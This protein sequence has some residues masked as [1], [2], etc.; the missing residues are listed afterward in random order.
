MA[1]TPAAPQ[2]REHATATA[3][4]DTSDDRHEAQGDGAV[5]SDESGVGTA[6]TAIEATPSGS[7]DPDVDADPHYRSS[8]QTQ[9]V[10]RLHEAVKKGDVTAVQALLERGALQALL[11]RGALV[12]EDDQDGKSAIHLATHHCHAKVVELLK[13][14][15]VSIDEHDTAGKTQLVCEAESGGVKEVQFLLTNGASIDATDLELKTALFAAAENGHLEVARL[16]VENHATVDAV[17]QQSR[18]PLFDAA[19]QGHVE[20]VKFLVDRG[21][22]VDA[23]QKLGRTPLMLAVSNG[24]LDVASFLLEHSSAAAILHKDKNGWT[25]LHVAVGNGRTELVSLLVAKNASIDE[26]GPGGV[27]PLYLAAQHGHAKVV[28]LLIKA[29]AAVDA[30]QDQGRTSL[31]AAVENGSVQIAKLLIDAGASVHEHDEDGIS[32]LHAAASKGHAAIAQLLVAGGASMNVRDSQEKTALMAAAKFGHFEIVKFLVAKRANVDDTETFGRTALMLAISNRH[33]QVVDFLLDSGASLEVK[34]HAGWS[35]LHVAAGIKEK[36]VILSMLI[37][38]GARIDE[39]TLTGETPLDLAI[40][41]GCGAVISELLKSGA[42]SVYKNPDYPTLLISA[43]R[44]GHISILPYFMSRGGSL[45]SR[46]PED[47][48]TILLSTAR[49]GYRGYFK[50]LAIQSTLESAKLSDGKVSLLAGTL[51]T[52]KELCEGTEESKTM[53]TKVV[54]RLADICLQLQAREAVD[55]RDKI[56]ADIVYRVCRQLLRCRGRPAVARFIA[57]DANIRNLR[58]LH[59]EI[60][61]FMKKLNISGEAATHSNW[62]ESWATD[63]KKQTKQLCDTVKHIT[64]LEDELADGQA[65]VDA[66]IHLQFLLKNLGKVESTDKSTTEDVIRHLGGGGDSK[67]HIPV[68]FISRYNIDIEDWNAVGKSRFVKGRWVKSDVMISKCNL[69]LA[70]FEEIAATWQKLGHPNVLDLFGACHASQPRFFVCDTAKDQTLKGHL[71]NNRDL[72]TKLTKLHEAA[73]G[74]LYLQKREIVLGNLTTE[75]ILVGEDGKTKIGGFELGVASVIKS[76][77]NNNSRSGINWTSPEVQRGGHPSYASDVYALGVC[78]LD[79]LTLDDP[80]RVR[81]GS[82]LRHYLLRSATSPPPGIV[83]VAHWR[84]VKEMCAPNP[85][86]RVVIGHVVRS[87]EYFKSAAE[88]NKSYKSPAAT[89]HPTSGSADEPDKVCTALDPP[90]FQCVNTNNPVAYH[91]CDV[92]KITAGY[93]PRTR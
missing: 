87:L 25:S 91:I 59:E 16:L 29:G 79:I 67:W 27:T 74:M 38:R 41:K 34:D 24:H 7:H 86:H 40:K 83:N 32:P 8:E 19:K 1:E 35:P 30:K 14:Y 3:N 37:Q 48:E 66:V 58:D 78:I 60:D 57:N 50:F 5:L 62:L 72:I 49:W 54:E 15:G 23:E 82:S 39:Q 22:S 75:K 51:A 42:R 43:G 70:Q 21:A 56:F 64:M 76:W 46:D 55:D 52:M 9:L 26:R 12:R 71:R 36:T 80:W 31:L 20:I 28:E 47:G 68:W 92:A 45:H 44:S 6:Q 13:A 2:E 85:S 73:L 84:L 65:K 63:K 18:T 33:Q 89:Q 17:D 81:F 69:E 53:Y 10:E 90:R 11:E 93:Y 88:A 61:S 77:N 4:D